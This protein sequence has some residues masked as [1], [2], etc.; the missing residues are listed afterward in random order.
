VD[1]ANVAVRITVE[2]AERKVAEIVDEARRKATAL[3]AQYKALQ[4]PPA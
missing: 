2:D 1:A 4:E 3:E